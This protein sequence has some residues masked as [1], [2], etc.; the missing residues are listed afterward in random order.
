MSKINNPQDFI[1][2]ADDDEP[3]SGGTNAS[4][5]FVEAQYRTNDLLPDHVGNQYI[6]ALRAIPDDRALA[7]ML[8]YLPPFSPSERGLSAPMR[9]QLTRKLTKLFVAV[10]RV[11]S[12]ARAMLVMLHQGYESRAPF[13]QGEQDFL[14]ECYAQQQSGATVSTNNGTRG[15]QLSMSLTG[16]SGG[17]KSFTIDNIRALVP[18]LIYHPTIGRWQIP[19]LY[20]EMPYDGESVHT[21][22]TQIAED[23]DE[24]MPD[25]AFVDTFL[26]GGRGGN[27]AEER[28]YRVLRAARKHGLG[29]LIVDESQNQRSL[30]NEEPTKQRK[31]ASARGVKVE[32][33]L[34]KLLISASNRAHV[35]LLFVGTTEFKTAVGTRFTKARRS[36]GNG[37]AKWEPFARAAK[38][39]TGEFEIILRA[40]FRYQWTHSTIEYSEAWA[41]LFFEYSQGLTDIV[42][43]LWASAQ[44]LAISEKTEL[45]TSEI[46]KMAFDQECDAAKFGLTALKN[47]D[48]LMLDIVSDLF[49]PE[50]EVGQ[51]S[52]AEFGA[53]LAATP[54]GQSHPRNVPVKEAS[55]DV[56]APDAP[57]GAPKKSPANSKRKKPEPKGPIPRAVDPELVKAADL[58]GLTADAIQT[59]AAGAFQTSPFG[60]GYQPGA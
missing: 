5:P 60:A 48:R 17:G 27:N 8:T 35:P 50:Q 15:V 25:G 28:L 38:G 4:F 57:E 19:F 26:K 37:S 18:P 49:S 56:D 55:A 32:T 3:N 7:K 20:I 58:R 2:S 21:L 29:M 59:A 39:K 53:P 45:V 13:S 34:M 12:I 11:V 51:F 46:L 6:E 22:A 41:D 42:V 44:V 24:L 40:L 52:I 9:I 33:P 54:V 43:K 31:Q 36:S 1:A 47:K 30:G 14:R 10:P 23:I 16:P